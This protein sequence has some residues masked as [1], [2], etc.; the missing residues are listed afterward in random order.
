MVLEKVVWTALP[1]QL[2]ASKRLQISVHVAPRLVN[3]DGSPTPRKL[4]ECPAFVD[5]PAR[6]VTLRFRVEFDNGATSSATPA[7]P[8]NGRLWRRLLPADTPLQP[9]VFHD[10]AARDIHVFPARD[11]HGFLAETYGAV[12]A[13]GVDPP[14]LDDPFGPLA[15]F[16][17]LEHLASVIADSRSFYEEL[18]KAQQPKAVNGRVVRE[19][20]ASGG[21]PPAQQAVQNAFFEA[22]RFYH[23]PGSQ[24]PDLPADYIEPSPKTPELDFHQRVS[25]LADHP[26]VLRM[27][28]LVVDLVVELEDPPAHLPAAGMV[29][30][31]PAGRLPETPPMCPW[32]RYELDPPWFGARPARQDRMRRG[33]LSLNPDLWEL[34][35][36]D[37][38]G[39]AL[40]TVGFADTLRRLR[41]PNRRSHAT[42]DEA[43]VPA[44]HAAGLALARVRR[45]E[46]LLEDLLARRGKNT[47][48]E[49]G[50]PP[51]FDAEDLVR[52][53]R[54]DVYDA[55]APG[56]GQWFSLHRRVARHEARPT[57]GDAEPLAF[58]VTDEGYIKATT[59]SSERADHPTPSDDLYLHETVFGWEGWSLSAPRPG[60]R[61]VE[62]GQ[63]DG[64]GDIARHD[65]TEGNPPLATR[66]TVEPRTLPRLRVGHR[67]RL[68]A[69]TVDLAGNSRPFSATDLEPGLPL[70]SS[71]EQPYQRFEPVP[72]PAV[73]RR[74]RDTEGES[75]EHLVIRSDLEM[76]AAAYA[77]SPGVQAALAKTGAAHSYAADAQRHLA[78]P[79]AS[80]QMAEQHGRL[81][82]ALGGSPA[83]MTAALR[84][85]LR[86]EGTFLDPTIVDVATGQKMVAQSTIELIPPGTPMPPRRGAGLPDGA[87]AIYPDPGVV[88]PYLPDPLAIG[89]SLTG[90]DVSGALVFQQVASFS[91]AW[92]GLAPFRLRLSEGPLGVT[93]AGGVLEVRLPQSEVVYA[94]LASVFP[95][96]RLADFAVWSWVPQPLRTAALTEAAV[97]G[98]HVMLTPF[99]WVT[100]THAVQRPLAVPD[101]TKVAVA[102][103]LGDT[104]AD[105]HGPIANHAK[106]TGRLDVVADWTEDLDIV[107]DDLPRMRA[108]GTAVPHHAHAFGFDIEPTED[109]AETAKTGRVSRHQLGDTKYRR[110]VYHSIATT[111][112]REFLPRPIA[113]DEALIQRVEPSSGPDGAPLPALVRD[114]L[115]TARPAAPD[116]LAPGV[117][118]PRG[119][120]RVHELELAPSRLAL[121]P[122]LVSRVP[123]RPRGLG[124]AATFP[125]RSSAV[126]SLLA[127]EM[128]Q[129][130]PAKEAGLAR[131]IAAGLAGLIVPPPPTDEQIRT[132]LVPYVTSWGSDPVWQSAQPERPPAVA[133][134]PRHVGFASG[135]TL[136]ELSDA[137]RV[138]V[139]AHDVAYDASR[140]LWYCDIE[141]DAGDSYF[142]FVRLALA[143]YQPQSVTGAH[144]SRVVMTDFIQIAPDRTAEA[145]VAGG[146]GAVTVRGF[147]G[148][149][150]VADL[151]ASS[152]IFSPRASAGPAGLERA[153]VVGRPDRLAGVV[154]VLSG[155]PPNTTMRVVLQ[156]R[157]P[158]VPGDLGWETVGAEVVLTPAASGFHV[159]WTG[160]LPVPQQAEPGTHRLLVT[161][162]ETFLRS[163][164]V[165]GDPNVS[166]SP[167]DF[168][169]ERVVYADVFEL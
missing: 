62:P 87:Y 149:N 86:E 121:E 102:R 100:F 90:Y 118:L 34:F 130:A 101:T 21:L 80:E 48:I 139:A 127:D 161:E 60:K 88:L 125:A 166:T 163:D 148:R 14:S 97:Q 12:A 168:V 116:V 27:L 18:Y 26:A 117:R 106:S 146:L 147:S 165:P 20:V 103:S 129:A 59:A 67:Y 6:L 151:A 4:G 50:Q 39:A 22:Y 140:K 51:V 58:S 1:N 13:V 114:V 69:R 25:A 70:L 115:S 92:P 107:T 54:V 68:R 28:G 113:D 79:K 41:D 56:G 17:P 119:W 71:P 138:V 105:F 126:R 49:G 136:E 47:L 11:V 61:I 64:G 111:R 74:H 110:I 109:Q 2:D 82:A 42:P 15:R 95:K 134:F 30:V 37:V 8:A 156:R 23:R 36:V 164:L 89:V 93:F 145:Q 132:M 96:E 57:A 52:G 43:T 135:L 63:G 155:P 85:A 162:S 144:L 76:S 120:D 7:A 112:F 152:P 153:G 157:L 45:G 10:H 29:R 84:V 19:Q 65:P 124:T 46:T 32:T 91:G 160:S 133:D 169:R 158:G 24:R 75:L 77:A 66:L 73:L 38:D 154:G 33:L 167:V 53:Y 128:V 5:W 122:S 55:D 99:R 108:L 72:S 3:D 9:Y 104:Y 78:P 16:A 143:R 83:A 141:I 40:Q 123:L 150:H 137:A 35:Q 81:D 44:L 159:T 131:S 94:R 98:R 142:P 31:V